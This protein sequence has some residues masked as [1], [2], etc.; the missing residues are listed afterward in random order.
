MNDRE[1]WREMVKDIVLAA[2]LDDDDM[3]SK[4]RSSSEEIGI[5]LTFRR[6]QEAAN[7]RP[8][9]KSGLEN[10]RRNEMSTHVTCSRNNPRD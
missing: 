5:L 1:K 6:N 4:Y 10:S 8:I 9:L 2:R 7:E 3:M